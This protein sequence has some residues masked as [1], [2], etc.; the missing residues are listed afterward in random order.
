MSALS[1]RKGLLA[2][3]A[4]LVVVLVF[5]FWPRGPETAPATARGSDARLAAR[6]AGMPPA[7][8]D[9][10]PL[11]FSRE[12]GEIGG[13]VV[14]NVFAFHV[15]PPADA[16]ARPPAADALSGPRIGRVHRSATPGS[17]A[18][19]DADRSPR[20]SRSA[21]SASSAPARIRSS[22]SKKAPASSTLAEAT[23]STADSY[24][25]ESAANRSTSPSS[26]CRPRSPGGSLSFRP[27]PSAEGTPMIVHRPRPPRA[28]LLAAALALAV[29]ASGCASE[30]AFREAQDYEQLQHWDMAVMAGGV[31]GTRE[32]EVHDGALPRAAAG[33]PD[34]PREGAAATARRGSSTSRRWSSSRASRSTRRTTSPSRS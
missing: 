9:I 22:R 12:R 6:P 26:G 11:A 8:S 5:R 2:L 23:F 19:S 14:R 15:P 4:V 21:P 10:P 1:S 3:L 29:G 27:T 20:R 30:R 34:P 18:G 31:S 24:S 25:G 32:P 13:A 33:G 16:Q 7:P 28:L 17:D